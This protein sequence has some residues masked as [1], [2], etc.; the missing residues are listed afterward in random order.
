MN[1]VYKKITERNKSVLSKAQDIM[2]TVRPQESLDS[3]QLSLQLA[4][5]A[6]DDSDLI[7]RAFPGATFFD[8]S[9]AEEQATLSASAAR[10]AS[11]EDVQFFACSVGG[12]LII[13][14]RG[15]SSLSDFL[16][17]A[18]LVQDPVPAEVMASAA[19]GERVHGGFLRQFLAAAPALLAVLATHSQALPVRVVGHSLGGALA[20]LCALALKAGALSIGAQPRRVTCVTF[21]SPRVGNAAFVKAFEARV[22]AHARVVNNCDAV[23]MRPRWGYVHVGGEVRLKPLPPGSA[24]AAQASAASA[25]ASTAS[26]AS[27]AFSGAFSLFSLA[28]FMAWWCGSVSDHRLDAYRRALDCTA[29]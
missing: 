14:F 19:A 21:G 11:K 20:T 29:A 23:T 1:N 24:G 18:D 12:E 4:T 2:V 3:L 26:T 6:Y 28:S 10:A 13:S 5:L 22:D 27:A 15:S 7:Q 8:S 17:D 25:T 16:A 9:A